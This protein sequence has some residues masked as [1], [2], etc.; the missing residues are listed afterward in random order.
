[1]NERLSLL[2]MIV[3]GEGVIGVT[4]TIG[5]LWPTEGSPSLGNVISLISI[6]VM[7]VC[8]SNFSLCED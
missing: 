8:G 3:I 2:T 7:L 1:M 4:K 5:Y 6:V